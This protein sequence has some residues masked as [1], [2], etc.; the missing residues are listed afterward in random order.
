MTADAGVIKPHT[1]GVGMRATQYVL[2]IAVAYGLALGAVETLIMLAG[3]GAQ[4]PARTRAAFCAATIAVDVAAAVAF[5][6]ALYGGVLILS[7]VLPAIRRRAAAVVETALVAVILAS[8][9][10]LVVRSKFVF[11]LPVTHPYKLGAF[12]A[13][14]VGALAVAV[15]WRV[16]RKKLARRPVLTVA[17]AACVAAGAVLFVLP[18]LR[19]ASHPKTSAPNVIFISLDTVRADH[20]GCYGYRRGTSPNLD[21]FAR[22]AALY[23]NAICVQPT[24]NP[25]HV[26][27]FTGLYPA[28]HGVVSNFVPLRAKVSTLPRLLAAH[29]YE[30]A[31]V[32]GGFPLDR[33]LSNLGR[34]FRY[35]DDY[36]NPWSY[37]RH[38]LLYRFAAIIDKKLYGAMRPAPAVTAAALDVLDRRRDRP[39]FLFVH[40][41]DPHSPYQ[42]HGAAER[43]YNGA[44]AVAFGE[45]ER[46]LN[47][48]WHQY[49][50]GAPRPALA[51]AVEALYD[52]EI[53]YTDKS[54]GELLDGLR[55]RDRYAQTLV[56]VT[57]DH[58]ESFGEHGHKFHG[59]TVYD[60]ETRVC[61]MIKP[62]AEGS[63]P[64][65][66]RNQVETLCLAYTVLAAAGAPADAYR[67]KRVD[68]LAVRDD[69]AIPPAVGFSQTNYKE[70]LPN[71]SEVSARYCVRSADAKLVFDVAD[72]R[73]EYY[74]LTADPAETR[75][76]YGLID[77]SSY[78]NYRREL[79]RHV[80]RAA[81]AASR[82][83][84]GDLADALK[85][86]GYTN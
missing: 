85:S 40:Y 42:Y 44:K 66:V 56:I 17:A 52:D 49:A 6:L 26:S 73:Y 54:L 11:G 4:T 64:R 81:S 14:G 33:R 59:G 21:R 30:N 24:T 86:L 28:Q 48:R 82:R 72:Q 75:D 39:L 29:G 84:G 10:V 78:E 65:R 7:K 77:A 80:E 27:M 5:A 38:T 9:S 16:L 53:L 15:A 1:K 47:R 41:F 31:A 74:D 22:E 79:T 37:F 19:W 12:A 25:S 18:E 43:F 71:G 8:S 61:L 69:A 68:L 3:H 76:L 20:L 36:L 58:G 70:T 13:C 83:V 50:V 62:P 23:E 46:E 45:Q 32:I 35:Y 67:G 55:R 34:G 51:A 60:P 57:S 2:K 63:G